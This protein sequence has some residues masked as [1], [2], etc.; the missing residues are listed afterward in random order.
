MKNLTIL[1][2]LSAIIVLAGYKLRYN[3]GDTLM[4]GTIKIDDE[5]Q[6]IHLFDSVFIHVTW[7]FDPGFGRFSSNGLIIIKNGQA[8]MIDTPMDNEK[9]ARLTGYLEGSMHTGISS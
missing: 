8:L 3:G 2:F 5:I 4:A 9:T 7:D 6:L 1:C